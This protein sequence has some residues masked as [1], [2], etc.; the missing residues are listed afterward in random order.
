MGALVIYS[1]KTGYTARYARWIAQELS[2]DILPRAEVAKRHLNDYD[3]I[4]YGGSLHAS[5][6]RGI[7][8]MKKN[9]TLLRDKTVVIF[10]VGATP[11]RAE[12]IKEIKDKNLTTEE[13]EK[14]SFF[15]FRGGFDFS[16][17]NPFDKFLMWLMKRKIKSKQTLTEDDKGFLE[18]FSVPKDFTDKKDIKALVE[19]C[20]KNH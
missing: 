2:A 17:L 1:S 8:F 12:T 9:M 10:A 19:F 4:I 7:S 20:K 16:A 6:I 14:I 5:G 18:A 3:T 13:M 11:V 15:Y